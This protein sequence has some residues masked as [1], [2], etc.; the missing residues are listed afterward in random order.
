MMV[1]NVS[2]IYVMN[3]KFSLYRK[4]TLWFMTNIVIV[5]LR[6]QDFTWIDISR[7]Y[8]TNYCINII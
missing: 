2:I 3:Y 6:P 5:I 1:D 8:K 4:Q 7:Y